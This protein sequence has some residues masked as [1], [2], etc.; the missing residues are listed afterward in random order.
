MV[1]NNVY[2]NE[3]Q[4]MEDYKAALAGNSFVGQDRGLANLANQQRDQAVSNLMERMGSAVDVVDAVGKKV[5]GIFGLGSKGPAL[6]ARDQA[7]I[8]R[9][10]NQFAQAP[11]NPPA[12]DDFR[13]YKS[14]STPQNPTGGGLAGGVSSIS[15]Q[16]AVPKDL[17][18]M[19]NKLYAGLETTAQ[20]QLGSLETEDFSGD[21]QELIDSGR[22]SA[23][24]LNDLQQQNLV[25]AEGRALDKISQ[26]EAEVMAKLQEQESDRRSIQQAL[27]DEAALRTS[28]FQQGATDRTKAAR[29]A[30]GPAVTS[31]FEEVAEL[32]SGLTASQAMSDAASSTR[33]RQVAGMAAAERL[34]APAQLAAEAQMA[35]GDQKF[36]MENQLRV[37]LAQNI[38]QL[39]TSEREML[40]QEAMRQEQFGLQR[41]QALANAMFQIAQQKNQALLG[42]QQR[43]DS[44]EQ[45][46]SEILQQQGFQRQMAR[47][48]RAAS[49]AA[50]AKREADIQAQR[51]ARDKFLFENMAND[52][53]SPFREMTQ[54]QFDQMPEAWKDAMYGGTI[55]EQVGMQFPEPLDPD[56]AP[57]TFMEDLK[58][59][60]GGSIQGIHTGMMADE[61]YEQLYNL[62]SS[63]ESWTDDEGNVNEN[64]LKIVQ[65]LKDN[66]N[67]Q[68]ANQQGIKVGGEPVIDH[69]VN[70]IRRELETQFAN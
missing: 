6:S 12:S 45:R 57:P 55:Q 5:S 11:V 20:E 39:D 48:A 16:F 46:Q 22:L 66:W 69:I 49:A 38:A 52:P 68:L 43:L 28:Q 64:Y 44:I 31:E 24:Q 61:A 33:L 56:D 53:N 17:T 50:S 25:D 21:I 59:G 9:F 47:E 19:L 36:Q 37:Q 15:N 60:L 54:E 63:G 29:D 14:Q 34:A 2:G 18:D 62:Y 10:K 32:T 26:V 30:L 41:D 8:N 35:V 4:K 23:E 3:S 13:R 70:Q 51:E 1:T 65:D 67:S 42:E 58:S 7:E 40:L 27:A